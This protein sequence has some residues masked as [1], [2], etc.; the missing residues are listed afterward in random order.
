MHLQRTVCAYPGFYLWAKVWLADEFITT[1][2]DIPEKLQGSI[3]QE[4]I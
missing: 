1:T 2:V 3:Q 4:S